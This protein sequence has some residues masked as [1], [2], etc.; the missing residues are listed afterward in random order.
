MN[1]LDH[2]AKRLASTIY[3]LFALR[4]NYIKVQC[5]KFIAEGATTTKDGKELK[6]IIP[7]LVIASIALYISSWLFVLPMLIIPAAL[8]LIPFFICA[9]SAFMF[10]IKDLMVGIM[11]MAIDAINFLRR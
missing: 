5:L 10:L 7:K 11:D 1:S 2:L 9:V 4:T 3:R 6:A 8:C